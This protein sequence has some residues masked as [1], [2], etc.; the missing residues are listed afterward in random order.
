[1]YKSS[2]KIHLV[3]RDFASLGGNSILRITIVPWHITTTENVRE[4]TII[5]AR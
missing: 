2:S 5:Q 1:M 4:I 3:A